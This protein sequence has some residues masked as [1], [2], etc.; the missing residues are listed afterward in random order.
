MRWVLRLAWAWNAALLRV[1]GELLSWPGALCND[2][3]QRAFELEREKDNAGD[4]N[5]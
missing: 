1:V 4:T 2:A 3:E 5:T